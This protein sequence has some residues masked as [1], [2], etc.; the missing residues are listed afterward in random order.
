MEALWTSDAH[1]LESFAC[2]QSQYNLLNRWE[3]EPDLM[4]VCSKHGLG[5]MTFSPLA[6]G[7]LT[8]RFR[9]GQP[10]HPARPGS[11]EVTNSKM[12]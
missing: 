7:L 11:R 4:P 10:P 2:L 3:I 6:I 5:M 8:G 9:R 12:R 1:N